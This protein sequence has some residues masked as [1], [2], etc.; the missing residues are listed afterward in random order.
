ME[1]F[2][3]DAIGTGRAV[4]AFLGGRRSHVLPVPIEPDFAVVLSKYL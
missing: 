2:Q 1:R 3:L 4:V